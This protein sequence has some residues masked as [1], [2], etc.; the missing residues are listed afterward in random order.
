MFE[1]AKVFP[2]QW[3]ELILSTTKHLKMFNTRFAT[4]TPRELNLF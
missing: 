3:A 1:Q 2:F 4:E